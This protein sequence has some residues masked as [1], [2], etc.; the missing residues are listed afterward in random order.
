MKVSRAYLR[1]GLRALIAACVVSLSIW[2]ASFDDYRAPGADKV[3]SVS[4]AVVFTG[5]FERIDVALQMLDQGTIQ[6]LFISGLNPGAGLFPASFVAQFA[7][8]NPNIERLT[9][10][11][12][13]CIKWG[14]DAETT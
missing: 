3:R 6:R 2:F 14:V 1:V 7:A 4:A 5:Q 10:L 13:C 8:R 9:D 11:T 12:D